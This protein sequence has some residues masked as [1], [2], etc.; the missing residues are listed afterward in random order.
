MKTLILIKPKAFK[1]KLVSRIISLLEVENEWKL[2][3]MKFGHA[4]K[5]LIAEHYKEHEGK[6]FYEHLLSYMTGAPIIAMIWE[7]D[8]II[9]SFRS[10]MPTIRREWNGDDIDHDI[11]H[12]SDSEESAER[13]IALW[14]HIEN[15]FI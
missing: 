15:W 4:T 11:V 9:K 1:L 8:E 3:N 10:L 13:E 14:F 5:E 12:C 2:V 7:G 6:S